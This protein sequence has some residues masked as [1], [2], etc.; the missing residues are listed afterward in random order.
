[1][2]G[3]EKRSM[4]SVGH[5][6]TSKCEQL[7]DSTAKSWGWREAGYSDLHNVFWHVERDANIWKFLD[8][9]P[10]AAR[11]TAPS[12]IP[13][14]RSAPGIEDH[15]EES[16]PSIINGRGMGQHEIGEGTVSSLHLI[17]GTNGASGKRSLLQCAAPEDAG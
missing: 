4:Q 8:F 15:R 7:S 1:M 5:P 6:C 17:P 14:C 12:A 16:R 3:R 13:T 2:D 11:K 10:R 9:E